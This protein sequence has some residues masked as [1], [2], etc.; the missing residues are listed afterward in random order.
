MS[1]CR[2]GSDDIRAETRPTLFEEVV[3]RVGQAKGVI[4]LFA[5]QQS[6]V[7]GDGGTTKFQ[8]YF[9]ETMKRPFFRAVAVETTSPMRYQGSLARTYATPY[10]RQS[11][12]AEDGARTRDLL[13]GKEML[14]H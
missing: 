13:L 14:Y 2:L 4:K 11:L 3:G 7:G 9:T 10:R 1:G 12:G 5:R 6:C 8:V